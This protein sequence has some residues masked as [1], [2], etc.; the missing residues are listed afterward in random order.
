M[1]IGSPPGAAPLRPRT[2]LAW[3]VIGTVFLLVQGLLYLRADDRDPGGGFALKVLRRQVEAIYGGRELLGGS[4]PA[5]SLLHQTSILETGPP[6]QR[7]R[8]AVVAGD[9]GGPARAREVLDRL[10]DRLEEA[11]RRLEGD[12]ERVRSILRKLYSGDGRAGDPAALE[13]EEQSLLRR[14]LGW[15]G[16]LALAPP[17]DPPSPERRAILAEARSLALRQYVLLGLALL[18]L[19]AGLVGGIA[20]LV[21]LSGGKVDLRFGASGAP[22]GIYAETFAAWF[23]LFLALQAGLGLVSALLLP[24]TG[25]L[26]PATL[27][28]LLSLSALGWPV[29]RGVPFDRV[30]GDLGLFLSPA[31]GRDVLAGITCWFTALPVVAAGMAASMLLLAL[32]GGLAGNP[33]SL[34]PVRIPSHPVFESL[35]PGPAWIGIL[36]AAAVVAPV[37][38][39]TFFRGALYRHLREATGRAGRPASVLLSAA[40]SGLLF[41]AIHPQG[42]A[43]VPVLGAIAFG[44]CHAREWRGSL[45]APVTAH[46]LNNT[47]AT[48]AAYTM[49]GG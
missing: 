44:L 26:G 1:P 10:D 7:L 4:L 5:P 37:V 13:E 34:D 9:L 39:E 20:F 42:W 35:G 8:Y 46:A 49:I 47:V 38:E 18:A 14:E 15:F 3:A 6:A 2:G 30:R 31:P 19:G 29:L 33:D 22:G 43:A 23:V 32:G 28:S 11:G 36:V 27:A 16:D 40:A 41:A 45:V 24:A 25:S 21:L 12:E 17:S 48:I